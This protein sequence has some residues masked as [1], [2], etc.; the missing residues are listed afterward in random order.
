[1]LGE[2]SGLIAPSELFL[3]KFA[4]YQEWRRRKPIAI[5]SL[6]EFFELLG[7]PMTAAAIDAAC[8]RFTAEQVY[9]WLFSVLPPGTFLVDKTP[10]Y[11][12]SMDVLER[13]RAFDPYYIWLIRHPLGVMDSETRTNRHGLRSLAG[14]RRTMQDEW[15]KLRHGGVPKRARVRERRWL[16]Q[17]TNLRLFLATVA[18]DRQSSVRFEDLVTF[19]QRVLPALCGA[20]GLDFEPRMLSPANRQVRAGI[21]DPNFHRH[22]GIDP[23][24]AAA[25]RERLTEAQLTPDTRA[26]M[27]GLGYGPAA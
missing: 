9:R 23:D 15:E 14:V 1:M 16:V 25:W 4:D 13:S 17:N 21:G 6:M 5:E 11:A 2:H 27:Q 19:P 20:M 18:P 22:E 24:R 3:L 8:Q 26:L 7:R 12:A 10:S